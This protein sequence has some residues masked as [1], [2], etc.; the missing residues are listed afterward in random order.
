M[1]G[2]GMV[3]NI[4]TSA[5]NAQQY[6]L[7]VTA[8]NIANVNTE[9]Y[10]RQNPVLVAE[11]PLLYEGLLLGRGVNT[12]QVSRS[13]DQFIENKLMQEKSNMSSSSEMEKYMQV[14]EG[15]FNENSGT[16]ISTMVSDFWN[17]WYDISNNPSGPSE[18][19]SLYEQS[20][21]LSE[22]FNSLETDLIQ[23]DTDLTGAVTS[24]I[25]TIN[26]ITHEIAQVNGQIVSMEANNVANDLRDKRN[27]LLS[28]LN[29][30]LDVQ[31]FEQSDGSL[32]VVAAR[33]CTLV[34]GNSDYELEMGGPNGDRVTWQ[35]SNGSY[36]DITNYLTNGKLG[37]WLDIRDEIIAKNQL[38]LDALAKEFI[39]SVNQQ[40]SQGVGLEGFSSVTGEY[41]VTN[42]GSAITSSGLSYQDK[43]DDNNKT[44]KIWLF[45]ADGDPYDSDTGTTGL[46]GNPITITV[47]SGMT[48]NDLVTA[49]N[50]ETGVQASIDS[51]YRLNISIDTLE[52]ASLGSLAFSDD[53][54]NVLAAFGINT[55]FTGSSSGN[56]GVND[57][58]GLNKN[59]I[60]A[61][62]VGSDGT[63]ASGDNNNALAITDLQSTSMSISQWTCDRINGNTQGSIT[64]TIEDYYHSMVGAIGITSASVSRDRSFAEMMVNELSTIRDSIS[65]V[66]LDEEMTNLIKFQHAYAAAAKLIGVSDEMLNTLLELK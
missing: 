44:F 5:L 51:Q 12:E 26:K 28:E 39:W 59:F 24:G 48:T 60:A 14:L 41:A 64:S 33:G 61:A 47:T 62:Q 52:I 55:F 34:Q 21:L 35:S 53:D 49:I 19:I 20:L 66:S 32:T 2:I 38:D 23:I 36:V 1:S 43:V 13:S 3:L 11:Q 22:Q 42:P 6:G 10:S 30:Y 18:R 17:G 65:A 29:E 16:S 54:S 15:F 46:Q 58:I 9:G 56:M 8:Q 25:E 45:D 63:M 57:T 40:H 31:A 7:G 37:G 4:A 27:T 50:N